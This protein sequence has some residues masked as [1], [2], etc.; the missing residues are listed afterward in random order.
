[1]KTSAP[2]T[3]YQRYLLPHRYASDLED[4]EQRPEAQKP[5][6]LKQSQRIKDFKPHYLATLHWH[7]FL[8]HMLR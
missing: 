3:L 1:L 7:C 2:A 4:Q 5:L 6:E 8:P